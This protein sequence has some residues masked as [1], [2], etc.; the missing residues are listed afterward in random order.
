MYWSALRR[1]ADLLE[2]AILLLLDVWADP[3]DVHP[4]A[5]DRGHDQNLRAL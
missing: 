5:L 3:H 1:V 4:R 2:A